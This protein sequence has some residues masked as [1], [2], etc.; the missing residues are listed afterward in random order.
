MKRPN[1]LYIMADD[2]AATAI[3]A[4]GSRLAPLNPTPTIDA[5]ASGGMRFDRV[6]CVNSI[7]TPSRANII[8]GQYCQTNGVLNLGDTLAPERQYLPAE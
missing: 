5:L 4:Y 1:I 8:T 6:F 2:H 3:G 7:C